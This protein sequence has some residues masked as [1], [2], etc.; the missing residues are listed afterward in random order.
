M[1][2]VVPKP[3]TMAVKG[4]VSALAPSSNM[5]AVP[6]TH[7]LATKAH[8]GFSGQGQ[9]GVTNGGCIT[10]APVLPSGAAAS[11]ALYTSRSA[12]SWA[13]TSAGALTSSRCSEGITSVATGT[14]DAASSELE[15]GTVGGLDKVT[16]MRSLQRRLAEAVEEH[17]I[18]RVGRLLP[19]AQE[20]GVKHAELK[21]AE[22][23]LQH[24]RKQ[25]QKAQHEA[26]AKDN[27]QTMMEDFEMR[28]A[29]LE[30]I[31]QAR[32]SNEAF[33]DSTVKA[34]EER[35]ASLIEQQVKSTIT[36]L[37]RGKKP[38]PRPRSAVRP[39]ST[40]PAQ[41]PRHYYLDPQ[42]AGLAAAAPRERE[43]DKE[44]GRSAKSLSPDMA[45]T[46]SLS[47]DASSYEK[48]IKDLR[49]QTEAIKLSP[50]SVSSGSLGC[51]EVRRKSEKK[52]QAADWMA[53]VTGPASFDTENNN[54]YSFT[55]PSE[56]YGSL[57]LAPSSKQRH[58]SRGRAHTDGGCSLPQR[59]LP[60]SPS[61]RSRS[62]HSRSSCR[63]TSRGC[64]TC[65][66]ELRTG[67]SCSGG[68]DQRARSRD[69]DVL[70]ESR[71]SVSSVATQFVHGHEI[72]EIAEVTNGE[73]LHGVPGIDRTNVIEDTGVF[74]EDVVH[75]SAYIGR[76]QDASAS[77]VHHHRDLS[78][79]SQSSLLSL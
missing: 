9:G 22:Q 64:R 57:V 35:L 37:L 38:S 43:R 60:K 48:A 14:P 24:W 78:R 16:R 5:M 34:V 7:P 39:G 44:R 23:L 36:T 6:A 8:G 18:E 32:D 63:S 4:V 13:N 72:A 51:R 12:G 75:S 20:V 79:G 73:S 19:Q 47:P 28:L 68:G 11:T 70:K 10:T 40:S 1:P 2:D 69:N 76:G 77:P 46:L 67:S 29:A 33:I 50:G 26:L 3:V 62:S 31:S 65:G 25:C 45:K 66:A 30:K 56:E 74:E 21:A 59:G 61:I 27:M 15:P 58:G 55:Q 71:S 53:D 42:A 49:R 54:N 41:Y 52:V 17:N